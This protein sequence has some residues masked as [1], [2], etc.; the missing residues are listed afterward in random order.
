MNWVFWIIA[1]FVFLI[2]E[3]FTTSFFL[4]WFAIGA[5]AALLTS[6]IGANNIVQ[7]LVFATVSGILVINSHKIVKKYIDK[8]TVDTK[9]TVD[10]LTGRVGIVLQT[11]D[12][13]ENSGLVRLGGEQWSATSIEENTVIKKGSKVEVIKIDGVRLIVKLKEEKG[14]E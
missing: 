9:T 10:A 11:I 14:E 7:L 4:M 6:L 12:N 5:G 1:V 3:L 8:N 13:S 2:G